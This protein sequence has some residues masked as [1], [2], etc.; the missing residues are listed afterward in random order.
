M[1]PRHVPYRREIGNHIF[2]SVIHA[3]TNSHMDGNIIPVS[4]YI[5]IYMCVCVPDARTARNTEF[6]MQ[7]YV[8]IT[9]NFNS[10]MGIGRRSVG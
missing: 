3:S 8:N 2:C 6:N 4:I 7:S 1:E 9:V 10:V 5:Y